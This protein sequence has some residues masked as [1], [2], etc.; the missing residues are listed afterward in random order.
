MKQADVGLA[1]PVK[2]QVYISVSRCDQSRFPDAAA[3][4]I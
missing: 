4:I 1:R 2:N 3:V